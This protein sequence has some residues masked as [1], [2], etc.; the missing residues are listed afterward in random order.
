MKSTSKNFIYNAIYQIFIY[1]IPLVT[2][3]YISR[4]LGVNNIGIYS[5]TYS[6]V[7]YFMLASMLGINNYGAREIAKLSNDKERMSRKFFSIYF[8]QLTINFLMIIVYFIV[9]YYG[10]FDNKTIML[11]QGIYLIS[12]GLDINWFFF[13]L[14][15]FK[16]T[17]SRNFIIKFL[18]LILIFLFVKNRNDLWIYTSILSVSTLVS[19]L[20]LWIFIR[21]EIIFVK[22]KLNEIFSN[23]KQCLIL[24]IPVVSYSIYRIMDKTMI[25]GI[26]S[27]TEL[28][29]YENAE[30]IINIPLGF[31]SAL[32]TVMMPHMSKL[33]NKKF[34]ETIKYSFKLTCF[35]IFPMI[36]GLFLISQNFTQ[37]FFGSEFS[38]SGIII[39]YLLPTILFGGITSVI[40]TN[41]LIPKSKD[42]IYVISTIIGAIINLI[43]NII[44]IPIYGAV[45]A[46]IGT[47]VTEFVIMIYQILC[48]KN[49]I[50]YIILFKSSLVFL[51]KSLIIGFVIVLIGLFVKN[52]VYKLILQS[53]IS[54][55]IY[56]VLNLNY[57]KN[58]FLK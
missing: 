47:I 20:Y 8:L 53:L 4:V 12:C 21:K 44:F 6:I 26:V 5:Y 38:K 19:Q 27:A 55:I 29:Y 48:T 7:S 51:I 58:E 34:E 2:V 39:K 46:C 49:D 23:F 43:L 37:I 3:P 35:I 36:I 30:K 41:F 11:V 31:V 56:F 22:V 14:E 15:K 1:L 17:I 18:S 52:N 28:G 42:R 50:N 24:F 10:K 54:V 57:I 32:G 13:G 45:G 40:R 16:I 33:T 25:G 9:V